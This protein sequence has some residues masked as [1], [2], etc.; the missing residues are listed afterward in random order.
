MK[1][2]FIALHCAA[3]VAKSVEPLSR[4]WLKATDRPERLSFPG[5][6]KR[7]WI[8]AFAAMTVLF[9]LSSGE[10]QA[11][12]DHSHHR[13]GMPSMSPVESVPEAESGEAASGPSTGSGRTGGRGGEGED[14]GKYPPPDAA[15]LAAAFP[16]LGG[17][18]MQDHMGSQSYGKFLLDRLEAQDADAHVATVWDARFSWGRDFD[19]LWISSEGEQLGGKTGHLKSQV[20]WGHAF[21]RWWESTVGLRQDGGEGPDRT[22]AAFGVQGLAPYFFELSAT[23]YVGEGGR[24]ALLLEA[25]Y[26]LLLTN[27]L[28]LQPRLE[29]NAYGKD[30]VDKGTG[31]G[32]S[33]SEF[34]LR[35]RYEI[36]REFAPYVGVEWQRKYGDTADMARAAGERSGE[37]RAVAGIRFWY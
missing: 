23:G 6:G 18:S 34:G 9:F 35:L 7:H 26:E 16:D 12:E 28:I 21:S 29:L 31:K 22:W 3:T 32:L 25:E 14:S 8:P 27:R 2:L 17:M 20:F 5:T 37:A 10:L 11:A 33:D 36:R 24:T 13:M 1:T 4:R 30:D 15:Q 19:K